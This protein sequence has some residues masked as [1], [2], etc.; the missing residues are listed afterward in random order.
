MP[1]FLTVPSP[2]TGEHIQRAPFIFGGLALVLI[3]AMVV[4]TI[5]GKKKP[6]DGQSRSSETDPTDRPD[7]TSPDGQ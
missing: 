1:F 7:D 2:A 3:V 5:M 4:L 6:R